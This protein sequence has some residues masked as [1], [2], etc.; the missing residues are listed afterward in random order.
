MTFTLLEIALSVVSVPAADSMQIAQ[1]IKDIQAGP[2]TYYTPEAYAYFVSRGSIPPGSASADRDAAIRSFSA[3]TKVSRLPAAEAGGAIPIIAALF[4]RLVHLVQVRD[5]VFGDNEG[6]FDD[7][8]GTYVTNAKTQFMVSPPI[9]DYN[10]LSQ[11]EN[12]IDETHEIEFISKKLG[13]SGQITGATFNLKIF[14]TAY[15][16]EG[17]LSRLTGVAL[18]HDPNAWRQWATGTVPLATRTYEQQYAIPAATGSLAAPPAQAVPL[19]P[20]SSRQFIPGRNY[21]I[22]LTTGNDLEGRVIS[23]DETSVTLLTAGGKPYVIALTLI[24]SSDPVE[25]VESSPKTQ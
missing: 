12:F 16:G 15:I 23:R 9:L 13:A 25:P 17:A 2:S 10:I 8:V 18:G 19:S 6:D 5:A 1:Y 21:R 14:L 20:C 7:C 4:P 22:F 11:Y 3:V 24:R